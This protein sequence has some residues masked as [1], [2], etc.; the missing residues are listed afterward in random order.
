MIHR[1]LGGAPEH[2]ARRV[3]SAIVEA[4]AGPL[5]VFDAGVVGFAFPRGRAGIDEDFDLLPPAANG[6]PQPGCLG[7]FGFPHEILDVFLRRLGVLQRAGPQQNSNL[8]LHLPRSLE[9]SG[10]VVGGEDFLQPCFGLI[11]E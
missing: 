3:V 11:G 6:P 8:F 1:C 4:S 9:L 7:L 10:R 2:N 5:D